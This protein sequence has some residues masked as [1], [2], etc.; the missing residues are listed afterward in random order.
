VFANVALII[1]SFVLQNCKHCSSYTHEKQF[2]ATN[3]T[4]ENFIQKS[5]FLHSTAEEADCEWCK[6]FPIE[7]LNECR[8]NWTLFTRFSIRHFSC[9]TITFTTMMEWANLWHSSCKYVDF[10]LLVNEWN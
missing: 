5:S 4:R 9:M 6:Y 7:T 8:L 3:E 2:L 1:V 10:S